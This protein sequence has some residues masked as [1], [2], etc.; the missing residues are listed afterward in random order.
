M[1]VYAL[2]AVCP[3][4]GYRLRGGAQLP[5]AINKRGLRQLRPA[6][7]WTDVRCPECGMR[8][9]GQT[10]TVAGLTPKD[11]AAVEAYRRQCWPEMFGECHWCGASIATTRAGVL[12][13]HI[14]TAG[15]RC[16]GTGRAP[17]RPVLPC[18]ARYAT[19]AHLPAGETAP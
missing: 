19:D 7:T 1:V 3:I 12:P 2:R 6:L 8:T 10:Y 15:R 16:K 9:A 5:V 18:R 13:W 14:N 11:R 4:D 17:M